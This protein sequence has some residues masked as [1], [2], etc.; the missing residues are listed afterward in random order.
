MNDHLD[1][2]HLWEM[3][4][5]A[6]DRLLSCDHPECKDADLKLTDLNHLRAHV[7]RVYGVL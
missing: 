1:R 6:R 4:E 5:M 2:A 7:A 3:K